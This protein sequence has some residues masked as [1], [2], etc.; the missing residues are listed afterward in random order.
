[1]EADSLQYRQLL[2][3]GGDRD[4]DS[5]LDEM[6]Q[7]LTPSETLPFTV[8]NFI[9]SADGHTTVAGR[10]GALGDAGDRAMFHGLR[11]R[12]DAVMA[13]PVTMRT[14]RYGRILGKGERRRRR[15][16][17]GQSPEPLACLL[18]RSGDV[19]TEIPLFAE[20]DARIVVF[21]DASL[22]ERVAACPAQVDLVALDR[23][24]LTLT[25][26]LTRLR[27]DYGVRTLL[28]EG[29]PTLFSALLAE[30]LVDELCLT[31]A[32]KLVG[33]GHGPSLTS[34]SELAELQPLQLRWLLEREHALYVRYALA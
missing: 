16:E 14:E 19:P 7:S 22:Q 3:H 8:V 13:G 4:V 32:P 20:P 17:R 23:Q 9:A 1:M 12:V 27:A 11:E 34:G 15:L 5:L 6:F 33:G 2:P 24:M 30:R 28:C 26:A 29:G 25:T 21:G 31:V 18:T 10:S